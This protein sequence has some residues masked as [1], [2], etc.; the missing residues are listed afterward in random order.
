M[1]SLP[2]GFQEE[3][4]RVLWQYGEE[5]Y[6][7]PIA[8]AIARVR[9]N[10]PIETTGQL[11]ASKAALSRSMAISRPAARRLTISSEWPALPSVPSK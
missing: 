11:A 5:R 8:A 4:K 6:A 2:P 7:G 9:E 3:L 10:A 1:A